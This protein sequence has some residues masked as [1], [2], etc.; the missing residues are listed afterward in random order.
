M[1]NCRE[2]PHSHMNVLTKNILKKALFTL[3][4]VQ[5]AAFTANN[6]YAQQTIT[7]TA[8][9]QWTTNG[10]S[11]TISSNEVVITTKALPIP[12][13]SIEIF[14]FGHGAGSIS[15]PVAPTRCTAQGGDIMVTPQGAFAGVE[16]NPA[17]LMPEDDFTAGEPVVFGLSSAAHNSDPN[18]IETV[19]VT[20][21]MENGDKEDITLT[22]SSANSG[23][24]FGMLNS[25]RIPPALQQ[26]DCKLSVA[27]GSVVRLTVVSNDSLSLSATATIDFLVDPYGTTFDSGDG[28]PVAGTQVTIVD[29]RTGAPA[30]VYGDDGVSS[31]PS[32]VMT[33]AQVTDSGGNVY[34]FA[35]GDYRFPFVAPGE[36]RLVFGPPSP[37]TAPSEATPGDLAGMRH[38]DGTP[39]QII[40]ASY[41]ASFIL[42]DPAPV[43]IDV[44][45]D[46]PGVPLVIRKT[47]STV[48]ALPGDA[49]QYRIEVTNGDAIRTTGRITVND[50]LPAAMRLRSNTI[51]WNGALVTANVTT[52]GRDFSVVLP[53]LNGG[54]TGIL[55]Y[56]AEVRPDAEPGDAINHARAID[57][58][59]ASSNEVDAAIRI[60]R[61]EISDR[62]TII[63]RVTEGG[64]S[65]DPR[66]SR[67]I[68]GVRV[69]LQDGSYTV[70][71][72]EGRYHFEGVHPGL[73]VVQIEGS[74]LPLDRQPIDCAQNSRSA[75][76][77]IS[78]FVEGRGGDLKRADFR[79]I[80]AAAREDLAAKALPR[81]TPLEDAEAAGGKT[82]WFA[83]QTAGIDWLFPAADHN[84]R[85]KAVRVAIKH[86][87]GQKVELLSDGKPVPT[88]AFDGSR[89]APDN[90][91][92]V[93][94]WRGIE[95]GDRDTVLTARIVDANGVQ[96]QVLTRTVHYS[97]TPMNAE[98]L[99]DKS[100][101]VA[102]GVTRPV[103]AVRLTDRDG[104]PVKNGLVGDFS[105]PSP[106]YPAIE[107]DAQQSRQLSG[108]ERAPAVWHTVGDNGI[109]YIELE[110]TTASGSLPVTFTFR[111]GE[112]TR[113]QT[114]DTWLDPGN[115]P[116]TI[117][118][119]AAGTLGYNTLD[120]RMEALSDKVDDVN[121][122]ARIAL[123]AKGRVKGK[124]LMTLAYDSDK[125]VDNT[126]LHGVIDPTAYYTIYAD[127]SQTRY[128]AASV[129]KLY[130]KL[131]RPQFY[132]LFG[133]YDTNMGETQLA[134]YQ[135]T[136]N[137]VK[138][139]YRNAQVAVS[140]FAADTPYR[141]R[142]DELQ[143]AGISGPYQLGARMI[144]ANSERITL[145]V[146][147]RLH[148]ER[149]ILETP[150]MRHV[151]YDID[152]Y[153]GTIRF[154]APVLSRD[155][156]LNPQFIVATYEVEG[157]GERV[158]NAGGRASWQ[159]AD[160][161][162]RVG[163]TA[164]HD[165]TDMSKTNLGG[166]DVRYRPTLETEIRAEFAVT[167][168]KGR[169]GTTGSN[170]ANAW[171]IEAEH[172]DERFDI[173]AYVRQREGG[174]GVGQLN[175]SEDATRKAGFE[176][177]ARLTKDLSL[178]GS[179]W[180]ED[181]LD[182]DMMRR[183]GRLLA[184]YRTGNTTARAGLTYAHDEN[185]DGSVKESLLAQIGA[186]Q[187]LLNNKLELDVNSEFA[188]GGKD[189]SVDF[190]SRHRFGARYAVAKEANLVASY[191][192]AEG[193]SIKSRTFRAG[194]DLTP[195]AGGRF[196]ASGN[197]QNIDE[198]GPRTYAAFGLAQSVQLSKNLT[199]DF[200]VDANKTL[201]GVELGAIMNDEH[202]VASGGHLGSNGLLVEDFVAV[203]AGATYRSDNWST[204]G[205]VEY[206]NGELVNRY[207]A[208]LGALRRISEGR[209][210]GALFTFAR[211][212]SKEDGA[213]TQAINLQLSW[214]N[215]A[216]HSR[217]AWLNKLEVRED[218]VWDAVAGE[219]GP[220]GGP[221]L[222]VNGDQR[223][224]RVINS[225][226]INTVPLDERD[227][228]GGNGAREFVERGEYSFFWG[229]RYVS[230]KI[231]ADDIDGLSNIFG[232][233]FR[234]DLNDV[235]DVG[236]AGTV[237]ISGDGNAFA[238]S[239]GP[240]ITATPFKNANIT[241]GYNFT[242]YRDADFEDARYTRSGPYVTFRMK[243][244]QDTFQGLG[245]FGKR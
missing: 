209:N 81:E 49:V 11:Q 55:T 205:R 104:R 28:A 203:T 202:P 181:Y 179:A 122:D 94:L 206:R 51:R 146:R 42:N 140:A 131:E 208:N 100:M 115:R 54:Q 13:A 87:P 46:R 163:A 145:Q 7:N 35:P 192:I 155:S 143:G 230:D 37:Y 240:Q 75:G 189:E 4:A 53:P 153:D 27:P 86:L 15:A 162:L 124:W 220:I 167:D 23:R 88:V 43:R 69:M 22:E 193:D 80:E 136:L 78:R 148:S 239:G 118:G 60:V 196:T 83:G 40:D 63:G 77:A 61:D 156:D 176:G 129:R 184:E 109:A 222:L 47:T 39:Y 74:T 211:A 188:I 62:M 2:C 31:Y 182:T 18:A 199:A 8:N 113:T 234:F 150:M 48:K 173:L 149:I 237:R 190:P 161:K 194:L 226:S 233:D 166:I 112:T 123:Y 58:R 138:A 159:S 125:D 218:K 19:D 201:S 9:A 221:A 228:D 187:R 225:L 90:S 32:T 147:D 12:A 217:W 210:F 177:R 216:D 24:F 164:I 215:R 66:K 44:P 169:N 93:S 68:A 116:W 141:S 186:T 17:S 10:S 235:V 79:A 114:I 180:Q 165:E 168:S 21:T 1:G 236:A 33:G 242:G 120:D 25:A 105:V 244:D 232:A 207:G 50:A 3:M 170:S 97:V 67:G 52:N 34:T 231:G 73:H 174:F 175:R 82:D 76:S 172:H 154:R 245:L 57:N 224:R 30:I 243:F 191:E 157:V 134:A 197:Q 98:L 127:K 84:P 204:T 95:I 91:F 38:P 110:P 132:A 200:T 56:I 213:S 101:L 227:V 111:D 102:D 238:W 89:N 137:G 152:Y 126:R 151:D 171:L 71:D 130:L 133:D 92:A 5:A 6:A 241:V 85:T 72:D 119:F 16:T 96:V 121:T 185:A 107:A 59:G 144:L 117:V 106:Y 160:E 223:S 26:N 139:E 214:A 158:L 103:I 64:C 108:L 178:T 219:P 135:R 142:R 20:V 195:W 36:Y 65:I 229:A 99:R 41:G 198:Y 70:T 29:A 128:D 183:A 212:E 14:R 45:L